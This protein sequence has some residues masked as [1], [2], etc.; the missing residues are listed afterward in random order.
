MH[1]VCSGESHR[2]LTPILMKSIA[3]HVPFLS[4]YFCK[5]MPYSWQKV[6]YTPPI[7]I[8]IRLPFVSRYFC[9]SIRVRGRWNTPNLHIVDPRC[10]ASSTSPS[11]P[12]RWRRLCATPIRKTATQARPWSASMHLSATDRRIE[13]A[14]AS[15]IQGFQRVVLRGW[16][17][18]SIIGAVRVA[19]AMLN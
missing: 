7:C 4:R 6:V 5:S 9:R 12:R 1:L 2:P 17:G 18:I 19:V 16:G 15:V 8:T 3:I 13:V 10:S 14:I 11:F